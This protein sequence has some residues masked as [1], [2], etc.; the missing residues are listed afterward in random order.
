MRELE[1]FVPVDRRYAL[2]QGE[3]IPGQMSG[4]LVF[5]DV[6]GFTPLM[7]S[8][9]ADLGRQRGTEVFSHLLNRFFQSMTGP[10]DLY[11]GSIIC[12]IG[13]AVIAW[14]KDDNGLRAASACLRIKEAIEPF[15]Q[16]LSPSGRQVSLSLK[17]VIVE[18]PIR[19]FIVGDPTIHIMDVVAGHTLDLIPETQDI[20][21]PGELIIPRGMA[22]R[23]PELITADSR[24]TESA[25]EYV[26]CTGI[27]SFTPVEP[28]PDLPPLSPEI[29]RPWILPAVFER[30]LAGQQDFIVEL[31]VS[32]VCFLKF[33]FQDHL[34]DQYDVSRLD[35]F[36]RRVQHIVHPLEGQVF[37]I[38]FGDKGNNIFF[39][40]G[41][42]V[43]HEDD[44]ERA[45]NSSLQVMALKKELSYLDALHIG[46]SVG[47][48][49]TGPYGGKSRSTYACL[50]AHAN[51]AARLMSQALPGQILV[52]QPITETAHKFEFSP[53]G[54]IRIK[55]FTKPVSIFALARRRETSLQLQAQDVV[56][57]IGRNKEKAVLKKLLE[58]TKSAPG[59]Q[60]CIV[61]GQAG[62]GK[63]NIVQWLNGMA[64]QSGFRT[65]LSKAESIEERTPYFGMIQ[66][67]EVILGLESI[68]S[69][70]AESQESIRHTLNQM[71]EGLADWAPLLNMVLPLSLPPTTVT[72]ALATP[73]KEPRLRWLLEKIIL[74]YLAH[75]PLL[76][77]FEN[78]QW[79]DS[80]TE[81]FLFSCSGK[82]ATGHLLVLLV[83]RQYKPA[84]EK[85]HIMNE[86]ESLTHLTLEVLSREELN[87]L[88][89][90]YL[91]VNEIHASVLDTIFEKTSGHP[92]FSRILID[93]LL[94]D[95]I[96]M[97][98]GGVCSLSDPTRDLKVMQL[99]DSIHSLIINRI[100][101]LPAKEQL[102]LK[103]ASILGELFSIEF[104]TAVYP[105]EKDKAELSETLERL[106]SSRILSTLENGSATQYKFEHQ[107]IHQAVYG[108]VPFEL[109]RRIHLQLVDW[110]KLTYADQISAYYHVLGHHA[111][112]AEDYAESAQYWS[113]VGEQ[114]V[115]NGVYKGAEEVIMHAQHLLEKIQV[116]QENLELLL[117]LMLTLGSIRL[118][119]YGQSAEFTGDTYLKAQEIALKIDKDIPQ[120]ATVLFG[121]SVHYYMRGA[122]ARCNTLAMEMLEIG[123]RLHLTGEQIQAHLMLANCAFWL[124]DFATQ[125]RHVQQ[126]MD[127]YP[128]GAYKGKLAHY[129]QNPKIT[130]W[131]CHTWSLAMRGQPEAAFNQIG[132]M[133]LLA[134]QMEHA[135]S[136]GMAI[137]AEAFLNAFLQQTEEAEINAQRML[138][139][140]EEQG[141]PVFIRMALAIKG[142]AMAKRG[143]ADR[144]IHQIHDIIERWQ[145]SRATLGLGMF[146][147]L[148]IDAYHHAARWDEVLGVIDQ[149][150]ALLSTYEERIFFPAFYALRGRSYL[151]LSQSEEGLKWLQKACD[152]ARQHDNYL[153][154]MYATVHIAQVWI[155]EGKVSEASAL[156][157]QTYDPNRIAVN[158][159]EADELRRY[160]VS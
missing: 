79:L 142:W 31:R 98:H 91:S 19:R 92:L 77:I 130:V 104:L 20:V 44:V 65:I 73:D 148:L 155:R 80:S 70:A 154:G 147:T 28:W 101:R 106:K 150:E 143:E 22:D 61:E 115:E 51:L 37:Q 55:G 149:A 76:L 152:L 33:S 11:R 56:K 57:A 94:D 135:F 52:S 83:T 6:S 119:T 124:G 118:V 32:V 137:Q 14:F 131:I 17:M 36:I 99:P 156:F 85:L 134:D 35:E 46:I 41:A 136:K 116:T 146:Y 71:E 128:D 129:A 78:S 122:I 111:E 53:L 30:I 158:Q 90:N 47:H 88:L 7:E 151:A 34:A 23:C 120:K 25:D 45:L 62:V 132:R 109:R 8:Y 18:G 29:L 68:N 66:I 96:L 139:L 43:S 10:L 38:T 126:L 15:R 40:F 140:S 1:A 12:F 64:R 4:T 114:A 58:K 127:L 102:A 42:P 159:T 81:S 153:Y 27:S 75:G 49:R 16:F 26:L 117:N 125:D 60:W 21:K 50:G 63:S 107:I 100:D 3:D 160:F 157:F 138:E 97:I 69:N 89:C 67:L 121:L 54:S 74:S 72:D 84:Y 39:G 48:F 13:D 9:V 93:A 108:L 86:N 24:Y 105:V 95:G 123:K 133:H 141:F 113:K 2:A 5:A 110:I 145:G 112:A 59:D 103:V 82:I 87:Q 144:G